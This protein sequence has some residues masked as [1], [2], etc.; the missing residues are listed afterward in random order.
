MADSPDTPVS[1]R[2]GR[3]PEFPDLGAMEGYRVHLP[4]QF[5][6]LAEEIGKNRSD[7]VR[8]VFE[9][10]IESKGITFDDEG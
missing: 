10:Y 9:H 3:P 5:A 8:K 6:E 7:G 1:K 4:P 2:G